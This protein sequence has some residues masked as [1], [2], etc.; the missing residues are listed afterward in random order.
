MPFEAL[1]QQLVDA[2]QSRK[3]GYFAR[4]DRAGD[5]RRVKRSFTGHT[6]AHNIIKHAGYSGRNPVRWRGRAR[7][8]V[9]DDGG[10]MVNNRTPAWGWYYARA[11]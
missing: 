10:L 6:E 5:R 1:V 4:V 8:V 3:T 7:L 11:R 2:A 9:N